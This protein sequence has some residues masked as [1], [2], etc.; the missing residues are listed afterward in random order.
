M[1]PPPLDHALTHFVAIDE[2]LDR[3]Q[4]FNPAEAQSEWTA[5][6]SHK[7]RS[8]QALPGDTLLMP[9]DQGWTE[10]RLQDGTV[11]HSCRPF[12]AGVI[13]VQRLPNG[14]TFCGG[15]NLTQEKSVCFVLCDREGG[16]VREVSFTGDYVRRSTLTEEGT[17]LFTCDSRV[18]EGD[19]S[20]KV[21]REFSAPG[22]KHAWKA[23]RLADGH[24]LISAGYGAFL[25]QFDEQARVVRRWECH[26]HVAEVRPFFFGDFEALPDGGLLVCNWLGHGTDLGGTGHALLHFDSSSR[27]L[28]AWRDPARCSSLQTFVRC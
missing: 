21:L 4:R 13:S 22:F 27:L 25:V 8:L 17:I 19:W 23:V 10:L 5:P 3:I 18:L 24:T 9:H 1:N 6:L 12:A 16:I 2:G 28:G 26:E 14:E 15:L 11:Q 20:G 7:S